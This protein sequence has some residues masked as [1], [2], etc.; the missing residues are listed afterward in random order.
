MNITPQIPKGILTI[1]NQLYEIEKKLAKVPDTA[2]LARHMIKMKDALEELGFF[3]EDPMG[4]RY[5]ET[6]TD[7]EA[8][9]AGTGTTELVV[10]EVHKPIVRQGKKALSIVIQKGIVVIESQIK[11]EI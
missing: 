9:I 8:T 4:Q 5:M 7:L 2:G 3:Y 6:R 1:I 11:E 10:V